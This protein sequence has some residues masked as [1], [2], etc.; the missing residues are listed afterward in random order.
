MDTIIF[1]I[2]NVLITHSCLCLIYLTPT[3]SLCLSP[4]RLLIR[5]QVGVYR[6]SSEQIGCS[7]ADAASSSAY[8]HFLKTASRSPPSLHVIYINTSLETKA[9]T[10]ELVPTITCTSSNVVATILQVV[11]WLVSVLYILVD[12]HCII[13]QQ[14]LYIYLFIRSLCSLVHLPCRHL[15]KYQILMSGMVLIPI[16]VRT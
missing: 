7:L 15:P 4:L 14:G 6:M 11:V 3:L 13:F 12:L 16:W 8:T 5:T 10:H 9:H 2:P 1:W